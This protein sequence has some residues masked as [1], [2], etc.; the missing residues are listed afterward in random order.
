MG[1]LSHG[2]WDSC[3][4]AFIYCFSGYTLMRSW[5]R[6]NSWDWNWHSN[7]RC[8]HARQQLSPLH[9]TCPEDYLSTGRCDAF[10]FEVI[11]ESWWLIPWT[12]CAFQFNYN[13][14][15]VIL[16]FLN[17]VIYLFFLCLFGSLSASICSVPSLDNTTCAFRSLM[18][19]F[20]HCNHLSPTN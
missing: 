12:F 16:V 11:T 2:G 14:V 8:G 3:T 13:F 10:S 15:L 17:F 9:S 19:K 5:V 7:R 6:N 1:R 4:S 20:N 18:S